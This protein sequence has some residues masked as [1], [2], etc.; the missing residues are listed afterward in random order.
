M[1]KQMSSETIQSIIALL[2]QKHSYSRISKSESVSKAFISKVVSSL[3]Q[4]G[5][6]LNEAMKLDEKSLR[7][8]MYPT[9]SNK[10]APINF[11]SIEQELKK[12]SVT[13]LMLY[14]HYKSS[15]ESGKFYS[16]SSFCRLFKNWLEDRPM[17]KIL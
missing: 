9:K 12:P 5:I 16:Y 10:F 3:A 1:T 14:G 6:S 13:M 2:A 15:I 17:A 8:L 11:E 7:D 4:Q